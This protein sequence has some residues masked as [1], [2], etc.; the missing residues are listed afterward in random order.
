MSQ[1]GKAATGTTTA[2][3]PPA[4]SSAVKI[5][6]VGGVVKAGAC[7]PVLYRQ[8]FAGKKLKGRAP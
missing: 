6:L 5:D 8:L 4:L 3:R 1:A 7:A 2:A